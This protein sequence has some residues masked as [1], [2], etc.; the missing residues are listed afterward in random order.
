MLQ[1]YESLKVVQVSRL[2]AHATL[3]EDFLLLDVPSAL[4]SWPPTYLNQLTKEAVE[5]HFRECL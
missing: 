2:Q 5:A 3:P 1:L 4:H